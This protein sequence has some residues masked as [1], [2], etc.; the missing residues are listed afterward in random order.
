MDIDNNIVLIKNERLNIIEN[1][2]K[3]DQIIEKFSN[4]SLL[5]VR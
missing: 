2:Y 4:V 3:I 5:L 1:I